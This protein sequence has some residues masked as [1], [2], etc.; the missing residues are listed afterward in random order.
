MLQ[1]QVLPL[2]PG[3]HARVAQRQSPCLPSRRCEFESRLSFQ[4]STAYYVLRKVSLQA[5]GLR[6]RMP[7]GTSLTQYA[8]AQVGVAQ[9]SRAPP[10]HGGDEGSIPSCRSMVR[11]MVTRIT[12]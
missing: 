4:V 2:V 1:V 8:V 10:R 7:T 5:S 12:P 6:R 11:Q 9:W 3:T